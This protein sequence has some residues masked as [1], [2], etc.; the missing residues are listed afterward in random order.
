VG[1]APAATFG[2]RPA[3]AGRSEAIATRTGELAAAALMLL[4]GAL[5]VF[6]G[7]NAGGYFPATPAIVAIVLTQILLVR[8][9]QSSRPFAGFAPATLVAI[10]ALGLYTLLTLASAL[11]SHA[12]GRALIEFD[13]AWMYLLILILFGSVRARSEDLRR[14]IWGLLAGASIVCLAGLTSRV[15][16]NVWHTAPAVSNERLSYPVTY[17]NTLGLLAALGI[18]LA[19]HITC[20]LR[21]RRPA[22]IAAAALTPLLAATLFFTFSRGAIAAGAVGLL[23]YVLVARPSGLLSGALATLP[24]TAALVLAAYHANLLDTIDPTTPAAVIQGHH[25]ALVAG[26]CALAGAG[27]RLLLALTLDPALRRHAGRAWLS[28]GARAATLGTLA[29]VAIAAILALGLPHALAHDWSRFMSGASTNTRGGDLRARLSDPS[30][31]GR[32]D[33]WRVALNG[34]SASPLQGF[35]AGMYQTLW[36]RGRPHF[37]YVI[38]AHS[39]YLQAMAEL[40]VGGLALLLVLLGAVFVGL[41]R[42]ARGE[43]RSLYGALLAVCVVWALRAGIDWDWEMPV[44]TLVFFAVAGAALSPLRGR[45]RTSASATAG[46]WEAGQGEEGERGG[47]PARRQ[48]GARGDA[49]ARSS[50]WVPGA[51]ARMA[52]GVLCL[53]AIVTPV[54][55]IGSQ[56]RLG[57]AENA[58]YETGSCPRASSAALSSIGWLDVRPEPYEIVGFCDLREGRPRQGVAA[59][60]EAVSHD[61]GSWETHYA[62]ALAQATAGIDPRGEAEQALR[63][64]P[65]EPLT[66]QAAK[67]L[68]TAS[69]AA[70][71]SRASLL[72]AAALKSKDLSIFPS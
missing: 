25:V 31:D 1:G 13:R 12:L 48:A 24:A 18:V 44:V 64:D 16:P 23:V 43:H 21:E 72:R 71:V 56:R 47:A 51:G 3:A 68:R 10:A 61:P 58:L 17:W 42:R 59:M 34:F 41:A 66:E 11:W 6:T 45:G 65:Y 57:E 63:M 54:L 7:F 49:G 5:V 2:E 39:L 29:V 19:F 30:N 46:P 37:A 22:R 4:P 50:G 69:P 67:Q 32:T 52:L 60:G 40:G 15:L 8:I 55:I 26:I 36:D 35:G 27:L 62:L 38:D 14:L 33:L 20:S 70:W 28:R 53:L 9:L